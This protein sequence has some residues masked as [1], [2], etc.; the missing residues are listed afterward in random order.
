MKTS[1]DISRSIFNEGKKLAQQRGTSLRALIEE[2]LR[3]VL[4]K[5][6][7]SPRFYLQ[8]CSYG[9]DGLVEG[10]SYS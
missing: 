3:L 7:Q 9:E 8:D 4:Q 2:G 10:L 6:Q 5:Y 1:I